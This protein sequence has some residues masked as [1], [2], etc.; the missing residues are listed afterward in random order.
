MDRQMLG[1]D[2]LPTHLKETDMTSITWARAAACIVLIAALLAGCGG[3]DDGSARRPATYPADTAGLPD[4]M[5]KTVACWREAGVKVRVPS[6][7]RRLVKRGEFK[8][9]TPQGVEAG[10]LSFL[11][12]DRKQKFTPAQFRAAKKCYD[13]R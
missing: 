12:F 2:E 13:E 5:R 11:Q 10:F 1:R 3:D 8:G 9:D 6:A 4:Y 7:V